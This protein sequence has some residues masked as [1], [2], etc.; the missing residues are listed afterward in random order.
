MA[1]LRV[2]M[3]SIT[4]SASFRFAAANTL[5]PMRSNGEPSRLSMTPPAS[6]TINFAGEKSQIFGPVLASQSPSSK[7]TSQRPEA[8]LVQFRPHA[9]PI[10]SVRTPL[11]ISPSM[12]E[13]SLLTVFGSRPYPDSRPAT[14]R[15]I[16][17]QLETEI[18]PS[19]L[20]LLSCA[21]RPLI[22]LYISSLMGSYV[23]ATTG[24]FS[25]MNAIR[26][27]TAGIRCTKLVVPSIGSIVHVGPSPKSYFPAPTVS[28]P[29]T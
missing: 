21:P 28:S 5:R 7:N 1:S 4:S 26:T 2:F 17:S 9:P 16:L 19:C 11:V 13:V 8:M 15:S 27:Q 12:V 25:I 24:C 10:R 6:S 23:T 20:E 29:I 14:A 3:I 18:G 22:A